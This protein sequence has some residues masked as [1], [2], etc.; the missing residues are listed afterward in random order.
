MNAGVTLTIPLHNLTY[1]TPMLYYSTPYTF[2]VGYWN[3]LA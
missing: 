1:L 2:I 3:I